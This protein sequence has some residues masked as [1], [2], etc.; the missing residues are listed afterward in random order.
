MM[1]HGLMNTATLVPCAALIAST[2][3]LY[4]GELLTE[5]AYLASSID[6]S[7]GIIGLFLYNN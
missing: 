1:P 2:R 3:T 5:D 7:I 6:R 4:M